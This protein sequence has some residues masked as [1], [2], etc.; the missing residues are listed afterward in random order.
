MIKL[1]GRLNSVNVQKVVFCLEEI[2]AAYKRKPVG[3]SF[4]VV[5]TLDYRNKNPNGL[6]PVIEETATGLVMWESDAI[7]RH[8]SR[9]S[10]HD[11]V[12]PGDPELA[13][14]DQ[15][16]CWASSTLYPAM[17]ALFFRTVRLPRAEQPSPDALGPDIQ[18]LA[19][20]MT[21]LDEQ[22]RGRSY[23]TGDQMS[24]AD[25]IIAPYARRALMMPVGAPDAPHVARW[26]DVLRKRK[27]FQVIDAIPLG[28]CLEQWTEIEKAHG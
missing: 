3:G 6:V 27:S 15:W 1:W 11:R 7:V 17:A 10:G 24:F 23:V 18:R 16:A 21:I 26:L 22:M 19:Q 4:G 13:L 9:H 14:S 25:F 28:N 12:W 20:V 5:D 8:L 2:G